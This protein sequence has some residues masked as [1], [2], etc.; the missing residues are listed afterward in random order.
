[1]T[2]SPAANGLKVVGYSATEVAAWRA[3]AVGRLAD[4]AVELGVTADRVEA[5]RTARARLDGFEPTALRAGLAWA[6]RDGQRRATLWW[7]DEVS[8]ETGTMQVAVESPTRGWG[9]EQ[10]LRQLVTHVVVAARDRG[11]DSVHWAT[12]P[13]DLGLGAAMAAAGFTTSRTWMRL[14]LADAASPLPQNVRLVPMSDERFVAFRDF[15]IADYALELAESGSASE[16]DALIESRRSFAESLPEGVATAGAHLLVAV[17]AG[18]DGE[19]GYVWWSEDGP[20]TAWIFDIAVHE[21]HR[22]QGWG[23][24][25]LRAAHGHMASAGVEH[26][27]L[28]VFGHNE[29]A[30]RL[31]E[32]EG[33]RPVV[34]H[35]ALD[36]AAGDR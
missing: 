1:M 26:A 9:D 3:D 13:P 2:S 6:V 14:D 11:A 10:E 24:A 28:N 8:A 29:P 17:A 31:Y 36:L 12:H 35:W 4:E 7:R 20:G 30:A 19:L 22:R 16:A 34:Q 5:G 23:R 27:V 18:V 25:L 21:Q 32:S 33:Y 15:S